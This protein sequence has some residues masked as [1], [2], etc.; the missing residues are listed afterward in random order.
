MY[1]FCVWG[2]GPPMACRTLVSQ[3]GIEPKPRQWKR[4][5]LPLDRQGIP[6]NV[7]LFACPHPTTAPL[8]II[9]KDSNIFHLL[10]FHGFFNPITAHTACFQ[11]LLSIFRQSAFSAFQTLPIF[12]RDDKKQHQRVWVTMHGCLGLCWYQLPK[13]SRVIFSL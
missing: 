5:I 13:N 2:G 10:V 1:L 4:C 7:V 11:C 3:L 9:S 8:N 12:T 6:L